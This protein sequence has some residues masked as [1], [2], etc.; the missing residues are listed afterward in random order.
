V[1]HPVLHSVFVASHLVNIMSSHSPS[2]VSYISSCSPSCFS[3]VSSCTPVGAVLSC[4][5]PVFI[6]FNPVIDGVSSCPPSCFHCNSSFPLSSYPS[7][8]CFPPSC[9]HC[10][11]S[12]LR[13][14]VFIMC[15]FIAFI[16][17]LMSWCDSPILCTN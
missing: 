10:V 13:H 17:S 1:S 11:S 6:V 5:S 8:S 4:L 15:H 2:S 9:F 14:P 7:V 16:S 3:W 12:P